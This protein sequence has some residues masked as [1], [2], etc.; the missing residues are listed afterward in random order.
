VDELILLDIQYSE[1]RHI[2]GGAQG[3]LNWRWRGLSV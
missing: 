2:A 3:Q 1:G